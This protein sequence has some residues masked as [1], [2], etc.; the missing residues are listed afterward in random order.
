[1]AVTKTL[2]YLPI[3]PTHF[4]GYTEWKLCELPVELGRSAE[5]HTDVNVVRTKYVTTEE[6][7]I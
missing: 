4:I 1:M 2:L 3:G 5:R 6:T 7:G